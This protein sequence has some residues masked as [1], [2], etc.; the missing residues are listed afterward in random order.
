LGTIV[1]YSVLYD[2]CADQ[3]LEVL[4]KAHWISVGFY[5]ALSFRYNSIIATVNYTM[6][7]SDSLSD[8]AWLSEANRQY[9]ADRGS[10]RPDLAWICSPYDV[11]YKNPYYMGPPQPHPESGES[12][13]PLTFQQAN[14]ISKALASL[15]NRTT[16]LVRSG[17]GFEVEMI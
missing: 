5:F 14:K 10:L 12:P 7:D 17:E 16:R 3:P 2:N 9:A 4:T 1:C 8:A 15:Q 6:N 11:W 13:V